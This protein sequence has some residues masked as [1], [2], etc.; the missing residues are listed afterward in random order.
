VGS[1]EEGQT[2][3][4]SHSLCKTRTRQ[5]AEVLAAAP[6]QSSDGRNSSRHIA[7]SRPPKM[8]EDQLL[9]QLTEL[10]RIRRNALRRM[11]KVYS[12]DHPCAE[13][14][15]NPAFDAAYRTMEKATAKYSIIADQ[16]NLLRD[17]AA[18]KKALGEP[19]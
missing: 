16:I 18:M 1:P 19:P 10:K 17:R 15:R 9:D 5:P 3:T 11:R 4:S 14:A 7:Y 2:V 6:M 8:T 13:R 12:G